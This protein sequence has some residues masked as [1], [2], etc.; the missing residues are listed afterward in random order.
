MTGAL[1]ERT[2]SNGIGSAQTVG[3][4]VE[5]LENVYEYKPLTEVQMAELLPCVGPPDEPEHAALPTSSNPPIRMAAML[6]ALAA[7]RNAVGRT[8]S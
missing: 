8:G 2:R 7:R 1:G 6:R 5:V 3:S 4:F